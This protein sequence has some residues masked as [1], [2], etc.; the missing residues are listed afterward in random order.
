MEN[1]KR[2]YNLKRQEIDER[3][4]K[5][6]AIFNP[7][8]EV[9]LPDLVDIRTKCPPVFDQGTLGSCSANAGI[10]ARIMLNDLKVSLS[11]LFQYYEERV[12]ENDVNMD[13]GAQMRD[14]GLSMQNYGVCEESY[15]PYN[16]DNFAIPPTELALTN[17]IQYKIK[18]FH[19]V[20]NLDEIRQVL[21]LKQQPVLMGMEV[22]SSFE[23]Q[24]VS[25]TGIVPIP[26]PGEQCMGGHA[27]LIVG[28]DNI[29]K[30]LIVRNSWGE[31]WG[32]KGYFYLPYEF[33]DKRLAF[34]FWVL[35]N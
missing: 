4:F 16:V 22:Y 24:S 13:Y 15:F 5:L 12:L 11:R 33:I 20:A 1:I 3:D 34:D 28:Y 30:C 21:A 35:Q 29:K 2:I 32:D 27:V 14:I 23:S 6:S 26:Q 9:K 19:A 25:E 18:S 31:S 7:H 17:A 10:A 8:V